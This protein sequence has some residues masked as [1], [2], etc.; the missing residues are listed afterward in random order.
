MNFGLP[1]AV[2]ATAVFRE[3]SLVLIRTRAAYTLRQI[4]GVRESPEPTRIFIVIPVFREVDLIAE[5]CRYFEDLAKRCGN[6]QVLICGTARER[7]NGVNATL[8]LAASSIYDAQ[9]IKVVE[10]PLECGSKAEQI[11]Y[12]LT[13]VEDLKGDDF[14]GIYDVDSRP[15][16]NT[17]AFISSRVTSDVDIVQ[18]H[19]VFTGNIFRIN[20][21]I[22]LLGQALYQSRWT[23]VH[24]I[25]R[26][27]LYNKN[28]IP[29]VHLV[30]HGLFIRARVLIIYNGIPTET[31]IEDAHLGF[32]ASVD[33][34]T[35]RS[36][37][38]F[39][40]SD[41][42]ENLRE[43]FSQIYGWSKGPREAPLYARYYLQKAGAR[44]IDRIRLWCVEVSTLFVW[45][46]W[47]AT[48]VVCVWLLILLASGNLLAWLW[49]LVYGIHN[50]LIIK[51]LGELAGRRVSS[52]LIATVAIIAWIS[53]ASAP[54]ILSFIDATL[55]VRRRK[56]K[57]SHRPA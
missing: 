29:A 26:F 8:D 38:M 24:E 40:I 27:W 23:L 30:G 32:Y 49:L 43:S 15:S 52:P 35:I 44:K 25:G 42:P 47:S 2:A 11:N 45:A 46:R 37:P 41:S 53:L 48:S 36:L 28:I 55:G 6:A 33:N 31:D 54:V 18:Q 14:I 3:L 51:R 39:D 16:G 5:C 50:A 22:L 10:C 57:T 17:L 4:P 21:N 56:Y 34:L 7:L 12:A 19:A 9:L 13:T 20:G 1:D